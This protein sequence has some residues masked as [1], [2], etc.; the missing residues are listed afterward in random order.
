MRGRRLTR[1]EARKAR[2]VRLY[3]YIKFRSGDFKTAIIN[4]FCFNEGIRPQLAYQYLDLIL[5]TKPIHIERHGHQEII[6]HDSD[7]TKET[8][9]QTKQ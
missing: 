1:I 5:E 9:K 8:P 2:I 3:E 7:T 6:V 4:E